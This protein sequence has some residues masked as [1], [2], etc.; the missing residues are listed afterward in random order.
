MVGS[1]HRCWSTDARRQHYRLR[2][3][4]YSVV[5]VAQL[6]GSGAPGLHGATPPPVIAV[7][8]IIFGRFRLCARIEVREYCFIFSITQIE[9]MLSPRAYRGKV[10]LLLRSFES[11]SGVGQQ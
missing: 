7:C 5:L 4:D 11:D 1:S 3:Q 2:V 10:D 8:A 9:Q 6:A